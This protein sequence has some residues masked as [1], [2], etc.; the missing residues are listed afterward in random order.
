[1]DEEAPDPAIDRRPLASRDTALAHRVAGWLIDRKVSP[2][3]ISVASVF[4]GVG[5]GAALAATARWPEH[6]LPLWLVAAVLVQLRLLCNMLDGMVAV[7]SGQASPVG[8]LYNEVPD[9]LSDA[10]TL[11]GLGYAAGGAPWLGYTAALTAMLTAYVR[12]VGKA[13]GASND[14]RGPMAKPH[15][16][17]VVTVT[18][19]Y[20]ALAPATWQPRLAGM[21]LPALA[22]ALIAVGSLHTATRR[23]LG[24]ARQ[25]RGTRP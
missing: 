16:M 15:R 13:S 8:E 24:T 4:A 17:F 3:A 19:L 11:V 2:N 18:A 14:F 20:V 25:L 5:A 23:L 1:M 21:D 22:L 7:G 12:A 10:A 6:A 9:R